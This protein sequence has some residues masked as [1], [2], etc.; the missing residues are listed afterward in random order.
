MQ[1]I[2]FRV[3]VDVHKVHLISME[4]YNDLQTCN[5]ICEI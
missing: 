1:T 4:V 5:E 3:V 2:A